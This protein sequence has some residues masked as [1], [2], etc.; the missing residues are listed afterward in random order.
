MV[1]VIIKVKKNQNLK[2]ISGLAWLD[3]DENGQKM[4][5]KHYYKELK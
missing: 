5:A 3:K 1:Q 2:I 4:M